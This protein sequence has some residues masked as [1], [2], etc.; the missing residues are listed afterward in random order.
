[1]SKK[2]CSFSYNSRELF[3]DT[4]SAILRLIAEGRSLADWFKVGYNLA[5]MYYIRVVLLLVG[6][7]LIGFAFHQKKTKK[8]K[9]T[10]E[11]HSNNTTTDDA[12]VDGYCSLGKHVLLL[13]FTFGIW[14]YIWIYRT[15]KL[16]NCVKGEE[17]RN[18][19]KKLLLCMFIPFYFIYWTYK[20]AQ[21]V[22]IMAKNAGVDS[23][24]STL[25]L[26]LAIFVG[27]IPPILMQDKINSVV[28]A[29]HSP[30]AEV[31]AVKVEAQ[32]ATVEAQPA[33][34]A[35]SATTLSTI[36][37]LK[38]FKELLDM[39]VITQEEF[40]AKKKQLLGP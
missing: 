4:S 36:E 20:S 19:T 17:E 26:I 22:D 39:G 35:G 30:K 6:L 1:M 5:P 8:K 29:N 2:F 34:A 31:Q 33:K 13:L 25:C 12:E 40:D 3:L 14:L 15:T 21:R 37:E 32:P 11:A 24:L 10:S 23:D 27:I 28:K 18:P 7:F 9:E 38:A 16:L